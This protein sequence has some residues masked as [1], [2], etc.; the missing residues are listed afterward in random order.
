MMGVAEPEAIAKAYVRIAAEL[1]LSD[2]HSDA[3]IR[4]APRSCTPFWARRNAPWFST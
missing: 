2:R 3:G 4:A 1:G